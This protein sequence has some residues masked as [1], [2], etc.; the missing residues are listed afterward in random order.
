MR[1]LS[2]LARAAWVGLA[3]VSLVCAACPFWVHLDWHGNDE[4]VR[5]GALKAIMN[6]RSLEQ[7][8]EAS[9]VGILAILDWSEIDLE[10]YEAYYAI[11]R[12]RSLF[13]WCGRIPRDY[14][15]FTSIREEAIRVGGTRES[16]TVAARD[17]G[18]RNI[19]RRLFGSSPV[20]EEIGSPTVHLA[21]GLER[22][23]STEEMTLMIER[24]VAARM[25]ELAHADMVRSLVDGRLDSA[26]SALRRSGGFEE[27]LSFRKAMRVK[28]LHPQDR[29]DR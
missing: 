8:S 4:A 16:M 20:F 9:R 18:L 27:R 1:R 3:I 28:L 10:F 12:D 2:R 25:E 13:H 5:A 6:C 17:S 26:R 19:D 29:G 21:T 7:G 22:T 14:H 15:D 23:V 11:P 24:L